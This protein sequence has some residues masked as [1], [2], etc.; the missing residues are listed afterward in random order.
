MRS[1]LPALRIARREARRA[2]GRSALVLAMIALPVLALTFAAVEYDM[3][4]LT[5]ME[6]FDRTYGAA[7]AYLEWQATGDLLQ[8][9]DG[10]GS[11]SR[12]LSRG[13]PATAQELL[14][15]LPPGSRV[16]PQVAN[17]E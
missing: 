4:R 3:F 8:E 14:A 16:I 10:L 5:P 1:W 12:G 9:P 15:V 6:R 17:A 2:K 7:D 11:M 13:T